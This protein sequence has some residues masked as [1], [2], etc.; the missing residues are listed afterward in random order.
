M[1]PRHPFGAPEKGRGSARGSAG[2]TG[3]SPVSSCS[4]PVP[5]LA[6]DLSAGRNQKLLGLAEARDW[7]GIAVVWRHLKVFSV[8]FCSVLFWFFPS[9][10]NSP[11]Q[12]WKPTLCSGMEVLVLVTCVLSRAGVIAGPG[13]QGAGWGHLWIINTSWVIHGQLYSWK[14]V[15]IFPG[16]QPHPFTQGSSSVFSSDVNGLCSGS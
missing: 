2:G 3:L 6:L 8:L 16:L 14:Q 9:M 11:A 12:P 13:T 7:I 10:E 15:Q 4:V 1:Y 5:V